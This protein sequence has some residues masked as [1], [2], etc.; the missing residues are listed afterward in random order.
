VFSVVR[1][2]LVA[3]GLSA[4]LVAAGCG[5][6]GDEEAPATPVPPAEVVLSQA[7]LISE[8]DSICAEVNAAIGTINSSEATD[9]TSK[10]AQRGDIY[11]GLADRLEELGNPADGSA[12]TEVISAARELADSTGDEVALTS[13]Q[14]A[15]EDYGLD[16]C[17]E[18]PEAPSGT[19]SI[20]GEGDTAD[21]GTGTP[22]PAPAPTPAPAPAP[23]PAPDGGY[24]P[25]GGSSGGGGGAAPSGGISPG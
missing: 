11:L 12:P 17:A 22:A 3:V 20:S 4:A 25:G 9:E 18:E 5:G 1:N 2:G 6:G 24:S 7:E 23:A 8:A 10:E 19:P 21:S 13:F 15:A 16:S 14:Q